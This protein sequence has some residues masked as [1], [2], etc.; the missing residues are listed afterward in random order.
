MS[1]QVEQGVNAVEVN[2]I[3]LPF[4]D[5]LGEPQLCQDN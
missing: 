2:G 4:F 1:K 5:S 3:A